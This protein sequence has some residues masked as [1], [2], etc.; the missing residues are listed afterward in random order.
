MSMKP[1]TK[2]LIE[3]ANENV[4]SAIL[5]AEARTR[6]AIEAWEV[7]TRCEQTIA[8]LPEASEL[9]RAIA[10]RGVGFAKKNVIVLRALLGKL[11]KVET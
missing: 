10:N 1:R 9:E 7:V 5:A 4:T 11:V 6:E 2:P 3:I 8:E